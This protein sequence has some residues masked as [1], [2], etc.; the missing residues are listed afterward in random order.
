MSYS[1]SPDGGE[2]LISK[3]LKRGKSVYDL[4]KRKSFKQTEANFLKGLPSMIMQNGLGQTVAFLKTKKEHL[5]IVEAFTALFNGGDLMATIIRLDDIEKYLIMQREAIDYAGWLK[6]FAHALADGK[7]V[8]AV[9][10]E[11]VGESADESTDK[12]PGD[13][14]KR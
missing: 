14:G 3:S 9:G 8:A 10:G 11:P 5:Y 4:V 2:K 6:K 1:G 12:G 13:E 7:G